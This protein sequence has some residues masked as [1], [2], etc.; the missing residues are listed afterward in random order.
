MDVDAW[1]SAFATD[2][3]IDARRYRLALED[4]PLEVLRMGVPFGTCLSLGDGRPAP[5]AALNALDANKRV[6]YLRDEQGQIVARKLLAVSR[7]WKLL[8]YRLYCTLDLDA[9]EAVR[10]AVGAFCRSLAERT[11]L[12]TSVI[13]R[14]ADLHDGEW[15]DDGAV[16][17]EAREDLVTAFCRTLGRP[18]PQRAPGSLRREAAEAELAYPP[19]PYMTRLGYLGGGPDPAAAAGLLT[20]F[21]S[22]LGYLDHEG[23]LDELPR[24]VEVM[25]VRDVF[26]LVDRLDRAWEEDHVPNARAAV[27]QRLRAAARTAFVGD[28]DHR[29]VIGAL[30]SRRLGAAARSVALHVAAR[31]AFPRELGLR[32]APLSPLEVLEQA[33]IGCPSAVAAVRALV[34]DHP[35]FAADRDVARALLRQ[36]PPQHLPPGLDLAGVEADTPPHEWLG[37]LLLHVPRVGELLEPSRQPTGRGERGGAC[38]R[39]AWRRRA[40]GPASGGHLWRQVVAPRALLADPASTARLGRGRVDPAL[41]REALRVVAAWGGARREGPDGASRAA[42]AG[43]LRFLRRYDGGCFLDA[44]EKRDVHRAVARVALDLPTEVVDEAAEEVAPWVTVAARDLRHLAFDVDVLLRVWVVGLD[45]LWVKFAAEAYIENGD[46]VRL[47]ERA[48]ASDR[49]DVFEEMA[50]SATR[51]SY[52]VFDREP[53]SGDV[54]M[55]VAVRRRDDAELLTAY[56]EETTLWARRSAFLDRMI[57]T[58]VAARRGMRQAAEAVPWRE[59]HEDHVLRLWLW[60]AIE[61]ASMAAADIDASPATA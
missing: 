11:G 8:G 52:Y 22:R 59:T 60:D 28:P 1:L 21:E 15:H 54:L 39:S 5:P 47:R 19:D 49:M 31:F 38:W 36:H 40:A 44:E 37:D 23:L 56:R 61:R 55:D 48:E 42:L 51:S 43:A 13:G 41:V 57:A 45:R 53:P 58:G 25:A 12:A 14:P 50:D 7:G 33:P 30:R 26:P 10:T 17:F 27:L 18:V 9:Y 4:D 2:V 32:R 20:L 24:H 34:R 6:L 3:E 46:M 35:R 16:A 29:A